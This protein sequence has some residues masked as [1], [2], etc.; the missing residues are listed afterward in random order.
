MRNVVGCGE[1][2]EC[3]RVSSKDETMNIDLQREELELFVGLIMDKCG[4]RMT[5][6]RLIRMKKTIEERMK[7]LGVDEM[8]DYYQQTVTGESGDEELSRLCATI[9]RR[10]H[11]FFANSEL[12]ERAADNVVALVRNAKT[13][14]GKPLARVWFPYCGRG[15]APYSFAMLVAERLEDGMLKYVDILATGNYKRDVDFASSGIYSD[16]LVKS[17]SKERLKKFFYDNEEGKRISKEIRMMVNYGSLDLINGIYP[18]MLNGTSGL[19]LIVMQNVLTFFNW[20]VTERIVSKFHECLS[21]DGL[22]LIGSGERLRGL[23]GWDPIEKA[24]GRL[25]RR[26]EV[27]GEIGNT[28]GIESLKSLGNVPLPRERLA[29]R[30]RGR[31]LYVEKAHDYLQTGETRKALITLTEAISSGS[32]DAKVYLRLADLYA[33]R[34]DL[35][36]ALKQCQKSVEIDPSDPD[37]YILLGMIYLRRGHYRD[38]MEYLRKA[39]FIDPNNMEVRLQIAR[40]LNGMGRTHAARKV[41]TRIV[42]DSKDSPNQLILDVAKKA[43]E[44]VSAN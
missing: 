8:S 22:L 2:G 38:S 12:M 42:D 10:N 16:S 31:N 14:N 35:E 30:G 41:Y 24:G 39:L 20:K 32:D 27:P 4:M 44:G 36:S 29:S 11:P 33:S 37:A 28:P 17:V 23:P 15:M 7:G 43:L 6:S 34:N 25:Y 3:D 21:G 9:V 5:R 19:N 13:R 1:C 18:S 26:V 40:A